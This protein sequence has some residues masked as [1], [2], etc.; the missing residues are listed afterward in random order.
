MEGKDDKGTITPAE[1]TEMADLRAKYEKD[2]AI[3][4]KFEEER[5][6]RERDTEFKE[7]NKSKMEANNFKKAT[8][9]LE[10]QLEDAETK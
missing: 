2:K 8:M 6:A 10:R 9:K 3:Y 1:V 4:D 7:F 5:L